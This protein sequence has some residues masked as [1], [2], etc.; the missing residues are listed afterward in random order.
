MEHAFPKPMARWPVPGR[1]IRRAVLAE[2]VGEVFPTLS[3]A[4]FTPSSVSDTNTLAAR[5]SFY[6]AYTSGQE[7]V[8]GKH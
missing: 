8:Y 7:I 4:T 5:G 1:C 2:V 3:P 6:V